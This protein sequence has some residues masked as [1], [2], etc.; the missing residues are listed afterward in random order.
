MGDGISTRFCSYSFCD[1]SGTKRDSSGLRELLDAMELSCYVERDGR[2]S[3][4][5]SCCQQAKEIELAARVFALFDRERSSALATRAIREGGSLSAAMAM[6]PGRLRSLF[7]DIVGAADFVLLIRELLLKLLELDVAGRDPLREPEALRAYLF[8]NMAFDDVERCYA[9]FLDQRN[10]VIACE[11]MSE[12]T[13]GEVPVYPREILR[14]ALELGASGLILAHNHPSGALEPSPEDLRST[15]DIAQT[16][17]GLGIRLLDHII[18]TKA[19]FS[20]FRSLGL[21]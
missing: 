8:A 16:A 1:D 21:V 6:R 20:S 5:G 7:H 12:G 4:A 13:A 11:V 18:V 10:G 9:A 17:K 19:G 15:R 2:M 3:F 14:R